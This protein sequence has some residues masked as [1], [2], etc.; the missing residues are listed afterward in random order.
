MLFEYPAGKINTLVKHSGITADS[1][2]NVMDCLS[3][4]DLAL[5]RELTAQKRNPI[6]A[7][8]AYIDILN[9]E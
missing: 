5:V 7:Y 8:T 6:F 3:Q 9:Q 1:V 4:P 2:S